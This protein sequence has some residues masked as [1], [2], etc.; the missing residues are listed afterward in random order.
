MKQMIYSLL[1]SGFLHLVPVQAQQLVN[2]GSGIYISSGT[3]MVINSD[4]LNLNNGRI[5][6]NGNIEI[7]GEWTNNGNTQAITAGGSGITSFKGNTPQNIGGNADSHFNSLYIEND[8]SV[9][10]S[11]NVNIEDKLNILSG[12]IHL[13]DYD[14]NLGVSG[15]DIS[16]GSGHFVVTDGTGKFS[17]FVPGGSLKTFRVGPQ[18]WNYC[19][20]TN[21]A[22]GDIFSVNIMQD[23][24]TG[25]TTGTTIPEIE[26]CVLL[27]WN[28]SPSDI[29]NANYRLFVD[30]YEYQEGSTFDRCHSALGYYYN[31]QWNGNIEVPACSGSI[32]NQKMD[33]INFAGSFAVG[34][35]ESPMALLL[36]LKIDLKA[37]LEGPYDG[38][39]MSTALNTNN[40]I[41]LS[42]P[43][44]TSPWN[45]NGSESVSA[46]PAGVVDWVLIEGRDSPTPEQATNSQIF[47]KQAAF[48][49]SD[50]SI[51]GT[52]GV[53]PVSF[54]HYQ[55]MYELFVVIHH[56]NHLSILSNNYLTENN[57]VYTYDFTTTSA[58]AYNNGQK[59][60]E[61]GAYGMY[62]G[63]ANA[64]GQIDATD[65]SLWTAN[66]GTKGYRKED[67]NMDT[68]ICNKD[69]NNI[70]VENIN[71]T[72]QVPE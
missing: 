70:W 42:Q 48:L 14:L 1:I 26:D 29:A 54:L 59:E 61:G 21:H 15:E 27:T 32:H 50:G 62:G 28:V 22:A 58:Q 36:E 37:F 6:N 72:S 55:P 51:V 56:R 11:T 9:F 64:D 20:I 8:S 38:V 34:D 63:D 4:Y 19:Y 25:G 33:N 7:Y 10:L 68:Q 24:L 30:W 47:T 71:K 2:A 53:S 52:D 16:T 66:A 60:L 39:D 69:K 65:K 49:L 17:M 43:F 12:R 57:G 13:S 23:I 18:T 44:N 46:I 5:S 67:F 40:Q 3:N 45:Y 31:G 41:P 35:L